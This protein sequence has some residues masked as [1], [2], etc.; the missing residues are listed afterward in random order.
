MFPFRMKTKTIFFP[1]F[2]SVFSNQAKAQCK[3]LVA[4][5]LFCFVTSCS[6]V[7]EMPSSFYVTDEEN[8]LSQASDT[9]YS[10]IGI[11]GQVQKVADRLVLFGELRADL[12]DENEYTSS[13][14]REMTDNDVSPE[15]SYVD[16]SDF[17]AIINNCNYFLSRAD[18]TVLVAGQKVFLKEYAVVTAI[19]AWTYNSCF[20]TSPPST[21]SSPPVATDPY[22]RTADRAASRFRPIRPC[23]RTTR[24]RNSSCNAVPDPQHAHATSS[25]SDCSIPISAL[26]YS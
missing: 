13:E 5:L 17:Y 6:D 4:A 23:P 1:H 11:L 15:N 10:V 22:R 21:Q 25:C 12:V 2:L 26:S 19:R 16:Y 3:W 24:S 18:T 14:L 8:T 9:V 20:M 7:F